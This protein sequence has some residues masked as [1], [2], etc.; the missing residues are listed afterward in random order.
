[1]MGAKRNRLPGRLPPPGFTQLELIMVIVILGIVACVVIPR[2]SENSFDSK[3]SACYVIRMDIE[4]QALL[5]HRNKGSWP[6]ANLSDIG[7]D[8]GYFPD[9]LRLCP[10]DGTAYVLDGTTHRVTGHLHPSP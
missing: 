10:V 4:V 1:M 7:V 9:G 8:L 6:A 5:W 2:L 3:V